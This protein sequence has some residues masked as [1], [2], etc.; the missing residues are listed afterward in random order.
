MESAG[1][2]SALLLLSCSNHKR[3]EGQKAYGE[4]EG[5]AIARYLTPSRREQLL[6]RRNEIRR[7]LAGGPPRIYNE[8]QKGGFRDERPCNLNISEGLDFGGLDSGAAVYLPAFQ[9]YSG[10]FFSCTD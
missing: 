2:T 4:F 3:A 6:A 7:L 8:D 10:R 1:S 5:R 9:R